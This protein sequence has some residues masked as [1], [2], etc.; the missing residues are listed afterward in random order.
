MH[1]LIES[2]AGTVT[3][4]DG[5]RRTAHRNTYK[6]TTF[7]ADGTTATNAEEVRIEFVLFT[8][9]NAVR[10]PRYRKTTPDQAATFRPLPGAREPF[11]R[12]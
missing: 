8:N 12:F 7:S 11:G 1:K 5:T 6:V 9:A 2:V 3:M 4:A 10:G